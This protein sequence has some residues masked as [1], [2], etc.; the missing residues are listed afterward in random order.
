MTSK[1]LIS[2]SEDLQYCI[3]G[4]PW[5]LYCICLFCFLLRRK[6]IFLQHFLWFYLTIFS[7]SICMCMCI[8]P[9]YT[10]NVL[11]FGENG[12]CFL[13][14]YFLYLNFFKIL[15][16]YLREGE[17][18]WAGGGVEGEGEAESP[19]WGSIPEPW[20]HGLSRRQ[21]LYQPSHLGTPE[22]FFFLILK[23]A[24]CTPTVCLHRGLLSHHPPQCRS[25]VLS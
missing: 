21:M 11:L 7:I 24:L 20:D 17:R 15:F 10:A 5:F 4:L 22:G 18:A 19:M 25:L 6:S 3:C 8:P 16:I 1:L 9:M 13:I 23:R 12:S 14:F 2:K